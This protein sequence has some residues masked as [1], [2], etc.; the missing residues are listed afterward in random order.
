MSAPAIAQMKVGVI[1]SLTGPGAAVCLPE[2]RAI[3]LLPHKVGDTTIDYVVLDDATDATKAVQDAKRLIFEDHVDALIGPAT[4]PAALAITDLV[5]QAHVPVMNLSGS[6]LV[7]EPAETHRWI[8]KTPQNDGMMA[9]AIAQD[10]VR[11]GVKTV[12]FIGFND[13]FGQGWLS[14][15]SMLMQKA[16]IKVTAT[17]HYARTDTTVTGQVLR[18]LADDP[19]AVFIGAAGTPAVLP[20]A[21]LRE[22]D[23]AGRMYQTHGAAVAEF[24]SIGG[25]NVEGALLP[26]SPNLVADELP[27]DSP[28]KKIAADFMRSYQALPGHNPPSPFAGY[29]YD[30]GAILANAVPKALT[31]GKPGTE[32]F[33]SALR[34]AIE[35][36]TNF[37]DSTGVVTMSPTDHLGLDDRARVMVEVKNGGWH[38]VK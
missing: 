1:L 36:T 33:R 18:L 7:I 5:Q 31:S 21:T 3:P 24:L 8:F 9:Q 2:Q 6:S 10:I 26:V 27:A 11:N 15:M 23:Y 34:D 29:M 38:L 17:E 4:T 32:E 16:G 14:Q 30:A 28:T 20:E 19:D 25:R 35:H 22:H 12:G 13:A 37:V